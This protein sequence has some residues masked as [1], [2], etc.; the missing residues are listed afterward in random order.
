M[1]G[2]NGNGYVS[3]IKYYYCRPASTNMD[4]NLGGERVNNY[5]SGTNPEVQYRGGSYTSIG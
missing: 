5:L 2:N 3:Y 4:Y 1:P